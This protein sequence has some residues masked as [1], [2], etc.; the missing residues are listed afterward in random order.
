MYVD[1]QN[2]YIKNFIFNLFCPGCVVVRSRIR[3]L[4]LTGC[5]LND[6]AWPKGR[7]TFY[8]IL[9]LKLSLQVMGKNRI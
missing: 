2:V 6:T 9:L 8:G 4:L 3:I 1:F 5:V 7:A